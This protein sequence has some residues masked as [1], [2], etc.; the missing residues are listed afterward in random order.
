MQ[1]F[2]VIH[3]RALDRKGGEDRLADL[4][5]TGIKT[6]AEL[7]AISDDRYLSEMTTAIFKA[8]FYW[9]VID[10][11]WAGFEAAFWQFNVARCAMASPEDLEALYQDTRVIRNSQ[12][13]DTVPRN[14]FMIQDLSEQ[15]GS[16]AKFIADWPAEDFIGLLDLLH[17][18]GA[19][20]GKQTS[21][22]FLRFIGK[23]GFVLVRDGI[24]ALIHAGIITSAPNSKRDL[25]L[26][27][28]AFNVWRD[29]TGFNN[30]QISRILSLSIGQE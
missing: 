3:Q 6:V 1:K 26:V 18:N 25:K 28:Q 16:F 2:S 27:Q 4:L 9:K 24:S 20:L 19:R 7:S 21:Q 5:P 22:Y 15:Y 8:G 17:K 11:K 30:A 14:A 29:E 10:H 23:D 12:K 13:I